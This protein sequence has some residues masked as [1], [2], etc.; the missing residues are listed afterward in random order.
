MWAVDFTFAA[1]KNYQSFEMEYAMNF[2]KVSTCN[3][4]LDK[5]LQ[6]ST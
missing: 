4:F 2:Q 1:G 6:F 5:D 3:C